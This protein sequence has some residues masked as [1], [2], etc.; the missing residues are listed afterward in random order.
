MN[1]TANQKRDVAPSARFGLLPQ[2]SLLRNKGR[3]L[4]ALIDQAVVSGG[5]VLMAAVVGR[6]LGAQ[7]LGLYALFFTAVV[8]TNAVVDATLSS[9]FMMRRP[10]LH[11]DELPAYSAANLCLAALL[12]LALALASWAGVILVSAP[13]ARV[14]I[15]PG[16]SLV[17]SVFVYLLREHMRRYAFATFRMQSALAFDVLAYGLQALA[18]AAV[19]WA[20]DLSLSAVFFCV[21][22]GQG[23]AA[24]AALIRY[25]HEF[26]RDALPYLRVVTDVLHLSRWVLAAHI[27]LV[28]GLQMM[29]WLVTHRLGYA[30]AGTYSVAMTLSN[31]ANPMLT[32][33][34]N[35]M[36][37]AAAAAYQ[38][39]PAAV[40]RTLFHDVALLSAATA[41]ICLVTIIFARELLL[42][43]FGNAYV[44]ETLLVQV[45]A[46]S[47][48]A[49]SLDVGPYVGC[50]AMRRP[51]QNVLGNL[52]AIVLGGGFSLALMPAHGVL[53]AGFGLL[54]ANIATVSLRWCTFFRLTRQDGRGYEGGH[55]P[56]QCNAGS[57]KAPP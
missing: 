31:L 28:V 57:W 52:V 14:L 5:N 17:A 50:W 3:T 36:T 9:S 29:P 38:H 41:V 12:T 15:G 24:A 13:E 34:I 37:P 54:F 39:G 21:T 49:R 22:F 35:V 33:L 10:E 6:A 48:L 53:G 20:D 45:L 26:Q 47:F 56:V 32:G 4:S 27:L 55:E 18:V 16:L 40:R 43:L 1:S 8:L 44:G 46:A 42:I 51:D 23:V 2:L 19:C 30:A 25:R 11:Q 7:S